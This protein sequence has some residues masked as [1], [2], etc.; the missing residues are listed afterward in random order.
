M[1]IFLKYNLRALDYKEITSV[2]PDVFVEPNT[3]KMLSVSQPSPRCDTP[4]SDHDSDGNPDSGSNE[5][6]DEGSDH[7]NDS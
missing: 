7:G 6:S 3:G 1:L 2:V 5:S 4:V